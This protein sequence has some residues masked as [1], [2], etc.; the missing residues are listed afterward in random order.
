MLKIYPSEFGLARMAEEEQ[1]GPKEL[2]ELKDD[3]S[4]NDQEPE[5]EVSPFLLFL[6]K[7]MNLIF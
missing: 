3:H 5:E 7:I 2:V 4:A 6:L 1:K